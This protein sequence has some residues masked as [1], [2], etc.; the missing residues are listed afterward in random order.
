MEINENLL[1]LFAK[2]DAVI[3]HSFHCHIS[4]NSFENQSKF[5]NIKI[6]SM[7]MP[8]KQNYFKEITSNKIIILQIFN[9]IY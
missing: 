7:N 3:A 5:I 2:L 8:S 9:R 6:Y 1:S 4:F